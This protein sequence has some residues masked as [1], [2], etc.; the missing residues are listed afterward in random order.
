VAAA[1]VLLGCSAWWAPKPVGPG[2]DGAVLEAGEPVTSGMIE[3]RVRHR[4]NPRLGFEDRV[5][6]DVRGHF[7]FPRSAL[8]VTAKEFSKDYLLSL[9]LVRGDQRLP[10]YRE[11]YSRFAVR[12]R[13]ELRCELGPT[14]EDF[15]CRPQP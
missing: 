6:L 14:A 10:L 3:R 5:P 15:P 7:S 2:I 1:L 4:E 9:E 13:L 8:A 12:E 11:E